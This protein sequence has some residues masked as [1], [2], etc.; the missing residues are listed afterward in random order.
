MGQ[1]V[2]ELR[3]KYKYSLQHLKRIRDYEIKIERAVIDIIGEDALRIFLKDVDGYL[4]SDL[5]LEQAVVHTDSDEVSEE[6]EA[7]MN[8]LFIE[9]LKQFVQGR[10]DG[11]KNN[12]I[13]LLGEEAYYRIC[14]YGDLYL[15]D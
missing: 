7:R 8:I 10:V 2:E 13:D 15:E 14:R 11:V 1:D 5:V 3:S 4:F 6:E 12:I 9:Y